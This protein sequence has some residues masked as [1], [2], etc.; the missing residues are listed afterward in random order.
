[1][2]FAVPQKVEMPK[3]TLGRFVS[4]GGH[5]LGRADN[6][7][8]DTSPPKELRQQVRLRSKELGLYHVHMP[9]EGDYLMVGGP[10]CS[11]RSEA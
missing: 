8:W 5:P 2:D 3:Q 9:E 11:A 1:M 10:R 4:E 6:L 7:T